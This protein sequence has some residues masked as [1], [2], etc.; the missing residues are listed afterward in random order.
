MPEYIERE[1]LLRRFNIDDMMNVNGTLISLEN[2]RN[3]ISNFPAVDAVPVSK[4]EELRDY[5]YNE[6]LIFMRGLAEL[7]KLIANCRER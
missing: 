7:N 5:L 4:L 6:N 2:A 3:T 1:R